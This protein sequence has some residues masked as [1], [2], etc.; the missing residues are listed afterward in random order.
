M[1][2]AKRVLIAAT[3][4]VPV[5]T[6]GCA[7]PPDESAQPSPPQYT[8]LSLPRGE[9]ALPSLFVGGE[10][11]LSG[12]CFRDSERVR[13][14]AAPASLERRVTEER[15]VSGSVRSLFRGYLMKAGL[16]A[17]VAR[18]AVSGFRIEATGLRLREV[19]PARV[20]PDFTNPACTQR[21]LGFFRETDRAL[22]VT[23]LKAEEAR[24]GIS[25][26]TGSRI[27]AELDTALQEMDAELG[28]AFNRDSE[29]SDAT[30]LE[31]EGLVFGVRRTVLFTHRCVVPDLTLQAER[32]R[33]LC[34][35]LFRVRVEPLT[36]ER[37]RLLVT[38]RTGATDASLQRFGRQNIRAVGELHG[39]WLHLD[40]GEPMTGRFEGILV[41]A[42]GDDG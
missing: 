14:V 24:I 13:E 30:E 34:G 18:T 25:E 9:I 16:E 33:D 36:P 8:A 26:E 6:A 5:L 42:R 10:E 35:G 32:T 28:V 29:G 21:E 41:G 12:A 38:P 27:G 39:V 2:T 11:V 40:S 19:D 23:A 4:V 7:T 3:G 37:Y 15:E 20:R 1:R 17:D 31:G 22:V